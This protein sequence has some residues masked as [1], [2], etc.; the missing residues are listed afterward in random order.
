MSSMNSIHVSQV[1]ILE[2][3][4]KSQESGHRGRENRNASPSLGVSSGK[5]P[6]RREEAIRL[7]GSGGP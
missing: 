4:Y 1:N 3:A 5:G 2:I 6:W 7:P